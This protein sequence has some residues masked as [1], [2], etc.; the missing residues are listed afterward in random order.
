VIDLLRKSLQLRLLVAF[1][2]MGIVPYLLIM[3]YFSYWGNASIIKQQ[4][5]RYALQAEQSKQLIQSRIQQLER[6]MHFL[7]QLE[8]FDEMIALDVDYRISRLLEH[9]SE[10]GEETPLSLYAV[11][12]EGEIIASSDSKMLHKHYELKKNR[13]LYVEDEV[14]HVSLALNSSFDSRSLGYLVA[15]YPLENLKRFLLENISLRENIPTNKEENTFKLEGALGSYE[16]FYLVNEKNELAFVNQFM[17]FLS[18]LFFFGI[19]LI[20][21]ISRRLTY[22]IV[23]PIVALTRAAEKIIS[24][25]NYDLRVESHA[26]DET[27]KLAL[28]FNRLTTTTGEALESLARENSFRIQRFIDLT[29]MLNHISTLDNETDCIDVSIERLRAIIPYEINFTAQTPIAHQRVSVP[30]YLTDFSSQER[31]IYGYLIVK[32]EAFDDENEER[33]FTS[34]ATM[35]ML[36]IERILLI[37]EIK[38][39]SAAKSDFISGMSHEL[40]TP[41][42]AIIGFSQYLIAY[43]ELSDEQIDTVKKI[44]KASMHLLSIINDIL[45]ISKIEAGKIEVDVSNVLIQGILQECV[46]IITPLAEEKSLALHLE[47]ESIGDLVLRT[48]AKLSKQIIINLLSNAIKF[49]NDGSVTLKA[50][51]KENQL[52]ICVIDTG[53]GIEKESLNIIFD[54]FTQL[55][56][57][58]SSTHKGTGLGLSLSRHIAQTLNAELVL[59]SEGEDKGS[60]AVLVFNL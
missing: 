23:Q 27:G 10:I 17:V 53:I 12:L 1:L 30:L 6:E 50:V 5:T 2:L 39:A 43:E 19:T 55:K 34:V 29:D 38:S 59:E 45:D 40:R 52:I 46:D 56:N 8:I 54:A 28:M 21:F 14:L 20:Y 36:Q 25:Q 33:F 60:K 7:S 41:L 48:D 51:H 44:E 42:N 57:I 31:M 58:K 47:F 18:I 15:H 35:I 32:K 16:L 9:K 4:N 49:T 37:K 26:V 11:N 13:A 24:T 22:Q 3:L